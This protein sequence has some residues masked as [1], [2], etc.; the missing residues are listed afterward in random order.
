MLKI[1]RWLEV[2]TWVNTFLKCIN[3]LPNNKILDQSKLKPFA[4]DKLKVIQIEFFFLDKI[5]NI[6]GK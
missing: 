4:D 6:V 3:P 5:E 2:L 1:E